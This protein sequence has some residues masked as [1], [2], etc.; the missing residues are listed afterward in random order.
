MAARGRPGGSNN[1]T[2]FGTSVRL[3]M[4]SAITAAGARARA[5]AIRSARSSASPC[6]TIRRRWRCAASRW[7][8]SASLRARASCCGARRAA[9]A[10]R[11]TLARARCVTAEA[12]VALATR[13][14]AWPPRALAEALR[15]LAAHGDRANAAHARLLADPAPPAARPPRRGGRRA[16]PRSTLGDVPAR[17]AAV[18]AL[19]AFEIALRRGRAAPARAAL[20]GAREAAAR[21]GIAALLRRGRERGPRARAA[22]RA[23]RRRGRGALADAGRGRGG[24]RLAEPGRRRLP[25][26]C[27]PRRAG[28]ARWRAGRCCSRC[29]RARRGL[30]GRGDARRSD[31]ARV[32]RAP[33]RTS[34]TARACASRSGACAASCAP[35]AEIEATAG[36]FALA[37]RGGARGRGAGA[38]DR[39][40]RRRRAGAARR[41]RGLVDLG[42]RAGA[43]VRASAPCS[44]RWPSSRRPARCARSAAAARSAGS[45]PPLAGFATTL[46]LPVAADGFGVRATGADDGASRQ[47]HRRPQPAE[48]V[49]EYGPFPG[50]D[51]R[52][53]RHLRRPP[54]LVRRR[55]AAASPSTRRAASRVRALDVACDAGTAFDGTHLYQIAERA[56]TRSIRRPARSLATIPAPGDGRDSGLAWAEGTPV[57]RAVPRPQDPPDRSRRPARSCAP[58]SRTASSPA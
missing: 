7:P 4:D 22:R 14:L 49:R 24:A 20:A 8:S 11:E 48:I 33:A 58:S 51:A 31:R 55:R 40:P 29:A 1:A 12:E 21:S 2:G 56:S 18:A 44:A 5:P 13:D 39:E 37:P 32:R 23:P 3:A 6:A 46:L 47:T 30:A 45:A 43:R 38:A 41:R 10:P 27:A 42:A 17:L 26:G 34:P 19:V 50:A 54:G 15:T 52:A 35:L 53:R 28:G 57:G 9:S 36:G 16:A 25:A